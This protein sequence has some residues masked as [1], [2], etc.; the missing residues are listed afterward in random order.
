MPVCLRNFALQNNLSPEQDTDRKSTKL[1]IVCALCVCVLCVCVCAC[2]CACVC[3]CVR[4]RARTKVLLEC[5][6]WILLSSGYLLPDYLM[7]IV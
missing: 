4:A 6:S 2:V 7:L 1:L 3:V 5:L